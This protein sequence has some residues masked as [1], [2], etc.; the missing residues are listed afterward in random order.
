MDRAERVAT[1]V[2]ADL[3]L[4][5]DPDAD[6]IGAL[7]ADGRGG[8]RYITGNEIC[9]LVTWFK[10]DQLARQ[11]RMPE[12]PLVITTVVTTSLVTRIARHLR[13]AGRQ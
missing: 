1:E 5:T 3:V 7:A 4:A 2:R 12:S 13:R 8:F 10:L 9:A 11:G 6:R